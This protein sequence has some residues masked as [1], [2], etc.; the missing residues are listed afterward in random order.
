M[1]IFAHIS[2]MAHE[3][4]A[5]NLGQGFPD[6]NCPQGLLDRLNHHANAGCNQ[7]PPMQGVVELRR[8][9][10]RKTARLYGREV[11]ADTEVSVVAGATEG[12]FCAIA[13]SVGK[14]DE[15][16]VFDPVYDSYEPAVELAGGRCVH[17]PLS[18]VDFTVDWQRVKD[19]INS[20]TRMIVVN[21]PHNPSGRVFT[22]QDWDT[23][24]ELVR[25][26]DILI[27]SD[28]VYEHLVYDGN[29]HISVLC[30]G[31]LAERAFAV[32]SFGKTYNATGWKTGYVIAPQALMKELLKVH[33]YVTFSGITPI[34]YALADYMQS[35][36]QHAES[37]SG[38]YQNKRDEL[39]QLLADT[40]FTFKPAAAT[41]F[42][43]VDYSQVSDLPDFEM[44][45]W[46]IKEVGV[47]TI[48]ISVFCQQPVE[49]RYLRLC[50]AKNSGT[51]VEA[52]ERLHR[53]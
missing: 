35:H 23:L 22:S 8:E 52:V 31:E 24:A 50:F 27:L 10:A 7:Y 40:R 20:S 18:A 37:L 44:A 12:L 42:Q 28:E 45:E 15:V 2:Q 11:C 26:T 33:Q 3:F 47:A 5:L 48:P 30:H 29:Q 53:L 41:F 14:G 6:F 19:A 38:F 39:C 36:P 13:A 4:G 16:I 34:Q 43:L 51:L 46:L 1:T 17:I 32:S 21:T 49:A 25:G 9:I